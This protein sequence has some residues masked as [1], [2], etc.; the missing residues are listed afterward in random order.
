MIQDGRRDVGKVAL[1]EAEG[2]PPKLGAQ[3]A[4]VM[5]HERGRRR[6]IRIVLRNRGSVKKLFCGL[7]SGK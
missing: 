1:V 3:R 6:R 4:L 7:R 5:R 2:F